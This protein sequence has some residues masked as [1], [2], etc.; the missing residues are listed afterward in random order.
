MTAAHDD[1]ALI[2]AVLEF[3]FAGGDAPRQAWF[4]KDPAFDAAIAARFGEQVA[5]AQAGG[6]Q[7]WRAT[8]DGLLAY[9]LLLDQFSRNIYRDTPRAFAG[10]ALALAAAHAALE[11]G[12]DRTLP[13]VR[14]VFVY[15]PLEHAE[16]LAEQ[17]RSVALF[18]ALAAEWPAGANYLDY[19]QRHREVIA[20]FGRFPHRN[21]VLGRE[22]TAEEQVYLAQ[23][24]SG[25]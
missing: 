20:R 1:A 18:E 8:P 16:S 15:L 3:W 21:A 2:A 9:L 10:D 14:R 25:F 6:L 11:A 5:A 12:V 24:G 22:A 19:A 13:P 4:V 23:P 17:D 7:H